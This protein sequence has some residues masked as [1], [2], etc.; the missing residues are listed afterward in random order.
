MNKVVAF[1]IGEDFQIW[2]Q[3]QDGEAKM[4]DFKPLIGKGISSL[5][6]DKNYFHLVSID[7]A[8]GLEWPIGMDFCPNFLKEYILNSE[9][10]N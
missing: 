9:L 10:T 8:G 3:F 7:I 1:K 6:L 2:L 5:L 4:V